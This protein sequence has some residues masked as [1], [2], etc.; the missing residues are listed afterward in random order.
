M[1]LALGCLKS[2]FLP[3]STGG[4]FLCVL[5]KGVVMTPIEVRTAHRIGA[6]LLRQSR[7]KMRDAQQHAATKED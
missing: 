5:Y 7:E 1:P 4:F 6:A 3:P 2:E